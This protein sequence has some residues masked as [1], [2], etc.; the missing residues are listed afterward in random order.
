MS[1]GRWVQLTPVRWGALSA[2]MVL[3][4]LLLTD[5]PAEAQQRGQRRR[6]PRQ[7]QATQLRRP[8]ARDQTRAQQRAFDQP[9]RQLVDRFGDRA[10]QALHL[11]ARQTGRMKT[12]LQQSRR[13][14]GNLQA[15]QREIRQELA[16]MV[17]TGSPDRE[18]VGQLLDELLRV[19]VRLA[20]VDVAENRRLGEFMNP[21]QRARLFNLKQRLA[22]RA[23]EARRQGQGQRPQPQRQPQLEP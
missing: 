20:E 23:L 5:L 7:H 14:R 3:V 11:N 1:G 21:I 19:R 4:S 12:V 6:P 16:S 15:H 9:A 22:E 18:R 10:G 2:I 8:N 13:E 17:R